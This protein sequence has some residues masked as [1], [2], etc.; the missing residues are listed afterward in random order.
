MYVV[1]AVLVEQFK[2][3]TG[4]GMGVPL[5]LSLV[6]LYAIKPAAKPMVLTLR[7]SMMRT[8]GLRNR[9]LGLSWPTEF[10]GGWFSRSSL[11]DGHFQE[12]LVL[13]IAPVHRCCI[14]STEEAS[15]MVQNNNRIIHTISQ[16]NPKKQFDREEAGTWRC[17]GSVERMD[18]ESSRRGF[19]SQKL[20]R[21]RYL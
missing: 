1:G 6:T 8:R 4:T 16:P 9:C 13:A 10:P 18:P 21:A 7:A 11:D 20:Q 14:G 3:M 19:P 2:S 5:R 17:A 12:G 15:I